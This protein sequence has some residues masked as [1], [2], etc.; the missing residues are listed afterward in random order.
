[1]T[2][3]ELFEQYYDEIKA[4]LISCS[5]DAMRSNGKVRFVIYASEENGVQVLED[6]SGGSATPDDPCAKVFTVIDYGTSFNPADYLFYN[7][8][9]DEEEDEDEVWSEE[10]DY[11]TTVDEDLITR[12]IAETDWDSKMDEILDLMY[13]DKE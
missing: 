11:D 12:L 7:T 3:Q 8:E 10:A 2:K 9:I 5:E 4:Q 13:Y 1:M 6:I